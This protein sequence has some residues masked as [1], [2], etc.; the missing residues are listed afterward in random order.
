MKTSIGLWFGL[1]FAGALTSLAGA[2]AA[3]ASDRPFLL[4]SSAAADEDDDGMWSV[5]SWW[6]RSKSQQGLIVAAE[7]AFSPTTSVQ[8]ERSRFKD[9]ASGDKA[10]GLELEF[11]QLFN[12]IGRDG[13][14]WG[15]DLSVGAATFDEAGWR[16]QR[17]SVKLPYTLALRDGEAMLH[18]NAGLQKQR[19]TRREWV[20]SAAYEHKLG[21]RN[22]LFAELGREDRSTLL[23]AGV[24][25]WLKREKFAIDFSVQQTR[26]GA[27]KE[28]G[29]VI[30]FGW[31]DL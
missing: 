4:T 1:L 10:H 5:E 21:S 2:D 14:G 16:T 23:H 20:A 19:D 31:Y 24:R 22:T 9:R 8:L 18:V 29:V 7:Y 28:R 26:S 3:H 11:K 6:E 12:R 17:V 27:E 25:H 30:G 13:W 15:V